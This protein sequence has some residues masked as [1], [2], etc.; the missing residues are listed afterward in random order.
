[1]EKQHSDALVFFGASGDLAYKK[2][3]P[4]LQAMAKRGKLDFPV[5]GVA[6]TRFRDDTWSARVL[7][8]TSRRP[9]FVTAAGLDQ[10]RAAE[11]VLGMHGKHRIP[12]LL[13]RADRLAGAA[14]CE[15][16]AGRALR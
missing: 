11:L 14:A 9:L 1:M 3:F 8:G 7:R 16:S 12:S 4:A 13:Q 2:I 5:V 6:K 15:G 10:T